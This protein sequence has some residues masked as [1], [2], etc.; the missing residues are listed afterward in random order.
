MSWL[1]TGACFDFLKSMR[2][3]SYSSEPRAKLRRFMPDMGLCTLFPGP[4][5]KL[6]KR[7]YSK[8]IL[9]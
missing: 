9:E 2:Y 3:V 6:E 7:A 5:E 1:Y 4:F 8:Y